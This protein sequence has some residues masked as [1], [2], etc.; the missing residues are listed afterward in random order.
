[1][2]LS[3]SPSFWI[4]GSCICSFSWR[5]LGLPFRSERG[6]LPSFWVSVVIGCL[7]R[8]SWAQFILISIQSWLRALSFGKFFGSFF[9]FFPTFFNG[10][11]TGPQGSGN[12]VGDI[13]GSWYTFSFFPWIALPIFLSIRRKGEDSRILTAARRFAAIPLFLLPALWTVFLEGIFR[14][15]WPGSMNLVSD[16]AYLTVF[17][18]FFVMGYLLGTITEFLRQLK[19]QGNHPGTWDYGLPR[20]D[21]HLYIFHRSRWI[22]PCQYHCAGVSGDS[23]IRARYGGHGFRT[24]LLEQAKQSAGDH[25]DLFLPSLYAPL[26]PTY[27]NYVFA[28]KQRLVHLDPMDYRGGRVMDFCGAVHLRGAFYPA[29]KKLFRH[30]EASSQGTAKTEYIASR[31][32]QR[33]GGNRVKPGKN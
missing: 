28:F 27:R 33:C 12:Y 22:Q 2:P 21:C 16:W 30:T 9:A 13:F 1:M 18:S 26:R 6:V 17:L 32:F 4:T 7:S 31:C 23:S 29:G 3:S 24:T 5:G 10:I 20:Q 19:I 25:G 11:Y 14:P 15:G 8:S